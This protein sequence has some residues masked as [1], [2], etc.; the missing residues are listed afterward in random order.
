MIGLGVGFALLSA[1]VWALN[2]IIIRV[3][4]RDV[5][6]LEVAYLSI[7]PGL[8]LLIIVS[9]AT[10]DL[11]RLAAVP[12]EAIAA[13]VTTGLISLSLA[14]L[15]YFLSV[16]LVGPSRSSVFM[17]TRVIIA[18]LLGILILGEA[19]TL[20]IA[21]GAVFMFIGLALLSSD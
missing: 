20:K 12:W 13:F 16:R 18:P 9:V 1:I 11:T 4:V 7:Y 19:F 14:R 21:V 2:A 15:F 3:G 10:T 5:D 8:L 17:S 6:T